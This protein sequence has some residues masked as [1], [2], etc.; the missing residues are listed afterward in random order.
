MLRKRYY[1]WLLRAYVKKWKKTI[2]LALTFGGLI[3]FLLL[4]LFRLYVGPLLQRNVIKVGYS[5]TFTINTLPDEILEKISYGLTKIEKNGNVLPDAA[6]SWEMKN[7]SLEYVFT[8][9]KN[10]RL[11]NNEELTSYNLPFDFKD[12]KKKPLDKYHVA[13]ILKK[14][15]APFLALLSK[16]ILIKGIYGLGSYKITETEL[17]A[18]FVKSLTLQSIKEKNKKELIYFYPTEKALKMAFVLG[19]V[20]SVVGLSDLTFNDTSFDRWNTVNAV[21][22]ITYGKVVSVF[23]N[24]NDKYLSNKKV[25]QALN[26]ALPEEFKEFGERAYSPYSPYSLYYS[27]PA[28]YQ[29]GELEIA[30]T[31]LASSSIDPKEMNLTITTTKNFEHVAKIVRDSWKKL[32]V[33]ASITILDEV[34]NDFQILIRPL[35][36]PKDPDQYTIWH[37]AQKN[38]ISHYKNLRIDKLLEDGR[39]I[40][41]NTER[42]PIYADFQKYLLDDAPVSFLYYPV[43]F[44]LQRR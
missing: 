40:T 33:N 35:K 18:N 7:N 28:H 24:N 6:S 43:E 42:V 9:K 21:R 27:K 14:P 26:Y 16:P 32:Q 31:L 1:A 22:N 4:N 12:A 19:E 5:G 25:R 37:T 34:P 36:I 2:L 41:N 3:F 44:T 15:Y 30:R 13:Y 20:D 8:L 23:Y 10:Q 38:N 29:I 39:I 11:H 17:N